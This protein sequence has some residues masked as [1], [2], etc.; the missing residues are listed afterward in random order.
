LFTH[1][2][3]HTHRKLEVYLFVNLVQ[4]GH[5]LAKGAEGGSTLES[6]S[7]NMELKVPPLII[8]GAEDASCQL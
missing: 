3:T 5:L 4:K 6:K 2:H 8:R 1:T 7:E